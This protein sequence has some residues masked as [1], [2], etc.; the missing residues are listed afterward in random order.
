LNGDVFNSIA[1]NV[2]GS[3]YYTPY[4]VTRSGSNWILTDNAIQTA[5]SDGVYQV[6]AVLDTN[7]GSYTDRNTNELTIDTIAP[8]VNVGAD[9]DKNAQFTKTATVTE[10]GSGVASYLWSKVS[11]PGTITF[12]TDSNYST[13]ISANTQGTY[14]IRLTATDNASNAGTDDLH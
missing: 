11:S 8:S 2:N 6:V 12:G 4:P 1:I 13:T 10:S 14:V 7:S 9:V 3:T 5:L